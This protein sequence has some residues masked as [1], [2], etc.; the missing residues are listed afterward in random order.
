MAI[1]G[2]VHV[3]DGR[4]SRVLASFVPGREAS[5]DASKAL[6]RDRFIRVCHRMGVLVVKSDSRGAMTAFGIIVGVIGLALV[7]GGLAIGR[8]ETFVLLF[9]GIPAT[10]GAIGIIWGAQRFRPRMPLVDADRLAA[11]IG[12]EGVCASCH[13][14]LETL[15]VEGD[16]CVVCPECGAAWRR[17]ATPPPLPASGAA[18][19]HRTPGA[20]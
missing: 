13:Y 20:V 18:A 7:V 17:D 14:G 16:G 8:A 12:A 15:P 11:A 2:D 4:G 19:V 9:Y 3:R 10:L 6:G 1:V 5:A